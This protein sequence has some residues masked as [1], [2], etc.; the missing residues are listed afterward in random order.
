[1]FEEKRRFPR[2]PLNIDVNYKILDNLNLNPSPTQS[3]N[4]STDGI[5]IIMLENV[6]PGTNLGLDFK[7]PNSDIK[8]KA[9][10]KIAWIKEFS[11]G[12]T[13]THKAYDAGIEFTDISEEEKTKIDFYVN[14]L[15]KS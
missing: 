7:I 8:I 12:F 6:S 3:K 2:I 4:I 14:K 13:D 1:M 5:C 11:F 10:G 9:K 15:L